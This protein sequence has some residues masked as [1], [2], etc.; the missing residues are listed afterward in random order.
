MKDSNLICIKNINALKPDLLVDLPQSVS[1]VVATLSDLSGI[2]MISIRSE[3][4]KGAKKDYGSKGSIM[5]KYEKGRKALIID[6][7]V[8]SFA[9][10]KEKAVQVL[11]EHKLQVLPY[12][13]VVIDRE[14]GGSEKLKAMGYELISLLK[15]K[16]IFKLYLLKGLITPEL[17]E[18][19]L[20]F[21]DLA[22]KYALK[23]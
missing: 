16:E 19:S 7:V 12:I 21:S 11:K 2:E 15:L 14:E 17:Y 10:T 6:D 13:L 3:A 9:F 4:L 8:S 5:G 23:D 1:P 20:V 22:K 18:K